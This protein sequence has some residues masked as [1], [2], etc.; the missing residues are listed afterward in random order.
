MRSFHSSPVKLIFFFFLLLGVFSVFLLIRIDNLS[1]AADKVN[2]TSAVHLSL[3]ETISWLR[4]IE[5]CQRGYLLTKD[6]SYLHARKDAFMQ[7]ESALKKVHDGLSYSKVHQRHADTLQMLIDN[8]SKL[9]DKILWM[10]N[11]DPQLESSLK[12]NMLNGHVAMKAVQ[13]YADGMM[14]HQDGDQKQRLTDFRIYTTIAPLYALLL[15]SIV[16]IFLIVAYLSLSQANRRLKKSEAYNRN[17]TELVPNAIYIYDLPS[18][19]STLVNKNLLEIHGYTGQDLDE[20]GSSWLTKMVHPEDLPRVLRDIHCFA[21]TDTNEIHRNGFRMLNKKGEWRFILSRDVIFKRNENG[22]PEQIIGV[23]TDITDMKVAA[24]K[25][26]QLNSDLTEKN[27]DL[28]QA[29]EE[30]ASFN[31][32]ASHDLQEPLR[33]IQTF[34]SFIVEKEV[35]IS[36]TGKMYLERMQMSAVRMRNLIKDLLSYSRTTMGQD[37]FQPVDLNDILTS[38]KAMFK[39]AIDEKSAVI[40]ADPLPVVQGVDFQMQQLFENLIGNA[41]KYRKP[42]VMPVISITSGKVS[43]AE[44]S[45]HLRKKQWYH[46]ISFTDN[47]IGFEQDCADKIFELFQRLHSKSEHEGTGIGLAI[48]KKIVQCHGGYIEA[49]GVPN[50]GSVFIVYLPA[51]GIKT[52]S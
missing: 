43:C 39:S 32:I 7:M 41:I 12:N 28:R 40:H 11:H 24:E 30:L 8:R 20:M 50:K 31:F 26:D 17:I 18:G 1:D 13:Q 38:T 19:T 22:V 37:G 45:E 25:L 42:G 14:Q 34:I 46:K 9:L 15:I 16:I 47:G 33:K 35:N 49:K 52:L 6:S 21:A 5:S 27:I 10:Y 2:K 23:A 29:N 4:E 51:C 44:N 3:E 48:C 36:D